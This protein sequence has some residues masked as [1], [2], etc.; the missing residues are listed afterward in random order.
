MPHTHE[1]LKRRACWRYLWSAMDRAC[2]RTHMRGNVVPD[3]G[4]GK[5]WDPNL[6]LEIRGIIAAPPL[7]TVNLV[8]THPG[9]APPGAVLGPQMEHF[10]NEFV[11]TMARRR[12]AA[13]VAHL[14]GDENGA[15]SVGSDYEWCFTRMHRSDCS[16]WMVTCDPTSSSTSIMH[17]TTNIAARSI[18]HSRFSKSGVSCIIWT[19]GIFR[20]A[21]DTTF[22]INISNRQSGSATPDPISEL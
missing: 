21:A 13:A 14:G 3:V 15:R 17:A 5:S 8:L 10:P 6:G 18:G 4:S 11:F 2:S 22:H 19:T 20:D 16:S 7:S 9:D 1:K 12:S